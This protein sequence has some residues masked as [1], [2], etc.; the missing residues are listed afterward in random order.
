MAMLLKGA[1]VSANIYAESAKK[2]AELKNAGVMPSLAIVRVGDNPDDV[3]YEKM[4]TK[5]AQEIGVLVSH[6]TLGL[7][8]SQEE[9]EET[10]LNINGNPEIHGCLMLRPLPDG[11]DEQKICDILLPE[12]DIDGIGFVALGNIFMDAEGASENTYA[13]CTAG[14]CLKMLEHYDVS[15]QGKKICVVGR[16]LVIG[17]PVAMMLLRQNATVTICHSRT[18]DLPSVVRDAD[19]VICA[20]GRA[21]MFDPSFF[22]EGQVV[23]D[24]GINY[25]DGKMCG[26]VNFEEAL[27]V[28]GDAGCIT[29]VPGGIGSVTTAVLLENLVCAAQAALA[30]ANVAT[31]PVRASEEEQ[32]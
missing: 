29:P 16:S 21:K 17:K 7:D 23:L 28:L 2:I 26:D 14:A 31:T 3:Y 1:S 8:A 6:C 27:D 32:G 18:Q 4:A 30:K 19:I 5:K 11:I 20:I 13:P 25:H 24:V 22:S 15:V 10:I 9:I 12:K